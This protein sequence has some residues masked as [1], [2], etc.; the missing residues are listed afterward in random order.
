MFVVVW[1]VSL[2]LNKK[3]WSVSYRFIHRPLA[4]PIG[5]LGRLQALLEQARDVQ[6]LVAL[7]PS[8]LE[9]AMEATSWKIYSVLSWLW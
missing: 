9:L 7:P 3:L 1:F 6:L 2:F 4:A 5:L 8:P